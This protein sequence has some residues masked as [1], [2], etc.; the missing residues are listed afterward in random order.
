MNFGKIEPILLVPFAQE[1][2]LG[3]YPAIIA[4]LLQGPPHCGQSDFDVGLLGDVTFC[5]TGNLCT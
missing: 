2:L 4:T 3:C 5:F 1:R